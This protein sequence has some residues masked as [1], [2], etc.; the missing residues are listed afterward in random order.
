VLDEQDRWPDAPVRGT[1]T[2]DD[3]IRSVVERKSIKTTQ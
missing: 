1:T 3:Y 2:L